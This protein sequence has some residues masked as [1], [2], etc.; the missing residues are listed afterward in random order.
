MSLFRSFRLRIAIL[1]AVVAGIV[2][3]LFSIVAY[4]NIHSELEKNVDTRIMVEARQAFG[5][6]IALSGGGRERML[7]Q[8]GRENS[9]R[10]ERST[11]SSTRKPSR[12]NDTTADSNEEKDDTSETTTGP[13]N[14]IFANLVSEI[15]DNGREEKYRTKNWPA[16]LA[17]DAA[18]YGEAKT[19]E[20]TEMNDLLRG[21]RSRPPENSS[22][23]P[24]RKPQKD[25][26]PPDSVSGANQTE[27]AEPERRPGERS[28][29]SGRSRSR[30]RGGLF[31]TREPQFH[32]RTA[33][34][35]DWRVG[36]F[37]ND[38][39]EVIIA[40]S[41]SEFSDNVQ[42]LRSAFGIAVPAAVILIA[43]G[44]WLVSG[45]AI[46]PIRQI[47]DTAEK[48]T[49]SGLSQRIAEPGT[50][51]ELQRLTVVLNS[52]L[53]RLEDGFKQATRF[54]ADASHELKTPLTI[55]QGELEAA[56]REAPPAS[57]QQAVFGSQLEEVTRLKRIVA[58]LLLLSRAD[59]GQLSLARERIDIS[60]NLAEVCE[61]AEILAD[62]AGIRL[63]SEIESNLAIMGDRALLQQVF[64]NLISNAVKYNGA[65][66]SIICS[67]KKD[68]ENAV[69]EIENTG[70]GIPEDDQSKVFR[71]FYRADA[72]RSREID[73]FGL[74]LN[75]ALEIARAHSG[76]LVLVKSDAQSTIFRLTI[77]LA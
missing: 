63:K 49:A 74:G 56:L 76:E 29:R 24:P 28:G 6:G 16:G 48:V 34:G 11:G 42:K 50:G 7:R 58:S 69:V 10:P 52:M 39:H 18:S 2:F 70:H 13:E 9:G 3:G 21:R 19:I 73:G 71:R 20:P 8:N 68:E 32:Y 35:I 67:L 26:P 25:T 53:D 38:R 46:R 41:L 23:P 55:M 22:F 77:P 12:P 59:A 37:T 54:S 43:L 17:T 72:A 40:A 65:D 47:A 45:Q 30:W 36:V 61:D 1:T 5:R 66:G 57:S 64:Q 15:T 14:Q 27:D 75:L 51:D 44:A 4:S 60:S 31:I 33:D 62:A